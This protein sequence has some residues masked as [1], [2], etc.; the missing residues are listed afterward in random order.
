MVSGAP[1]RGAPETN[2]YF[3]ENTVF[4]TMFGKPINLG[5]GLPKT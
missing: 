4:G 1:K 5:S 3:H 2:I